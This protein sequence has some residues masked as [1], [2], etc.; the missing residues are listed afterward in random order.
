MKLL[1]TGLLMAQTT[2]T[3]IQEQ[4]IE[5]FFRPQDLL[6]SNLPDYSS[7]HMSFVWD[8]KYRQARVSLAYGRKLAFQGKNLQLHV[9]IHHHTQSQMV[10]EPFKCRRK[11]LRQDL[12]HPQFGRFVACLLLREPLSQNPLNLT[13]AK[14]LPLTGNQMPHVSIESFGPAADLPRLMQSLQPYRRGS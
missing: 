13:F 14:I 5:P 12:S 8:Q 11:E 4:T 1:L 2:L 6:V 3:P 9:Q 7:G 10:N